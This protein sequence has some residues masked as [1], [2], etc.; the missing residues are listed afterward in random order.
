[1]RNLGKYTLADMIT[2]RFKSNKV[3]GTA[4]ASTLVISIFYMIAQL[5]GGGGLISLMLG[6]D[7]WLAVVIVGVLMSVYV[8]FGGMTATSWVQITKA[9]LL[10]G[11]SFVL[12]FLVFAK[13]ILA[14]LVV[15][16]LAFCKFD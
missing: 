2:S 4:A 6:I 16:I 10:L 1:M 7:Y 3:R 14:L 12:T 13:F 9:A 11:G 15:F 8:I 5:V